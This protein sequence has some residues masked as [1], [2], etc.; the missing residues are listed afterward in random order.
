[1]QHRQKQVSIVKRDKYHANGPH[2]Y[3]FAWASGGTCV[4]L[5]SALFRGAAVTSW[6]P[7]MYW[8]LTRAL[9][10]H[11][12][13]FLTRMARLGPRMGILPTLLTV[14]CMCSAMQKGIPGWNLPN[15]VLSATFSR[16]AASPNAPSKE[17][18]C[19]YMSIWIPT[20]SMERN[21]SSNVMSWGCILRQQN[22]YLW[23][24]PVPT[25]DSLSR[26]RPSNSRNFLRNLPF[27]ATVECRACV[28]SC[29]RGVFCRAC[30]DG[31]TLHST[32][33]CGEFVNHCQS[34]P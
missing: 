15:A 11:V 18:G 28:A 6:H 2:T 3:K 26:W 8:P 17:W 30:L 32:R 9:R 20:G 33:A 7:P 13:F 21:T 12:R 5:E 22:L 10:P 24:R 14:P 34:A 31:E 16:R 25:S 19:R 23:Q 1:M 27:N 29:T 4:P